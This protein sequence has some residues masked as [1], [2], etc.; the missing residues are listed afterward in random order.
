MNSK[1]LTTIVLGLIISG[2]AGFLLGQQFSN[3]ANI[4]TD[5]E[6]AYWRAPMDP[7]EVYDSA[8]KSRMGM[9]LVPVYADEQATGGDTNDEDKEVLYWRAPMDPT[10][11]Y[12]SPGKS[13]MGMDLVPV[14]EGEGNE[15]SGGMVNIDP[16]VVQNMGIKTTMVERQDLSR[17]IRTVGE[18]QYD[19]EKLFLVNTKISGW[20]E[21]LHVNFVGQEVAKGE[22]LMEIYSPELVSTQE[23][24]ILAKR[25]YDLL[26]QAGS[27][28]IAS[29]AERL[30]KAAR[31]RLSYW[32]ISEEEI[33]RIE[34]TQ[35]VKKTILIAAPSTG[36]VVERNAIEGAFI[37][38][39]KDLFRIAD[40]STVW[41]HASFYDN[42][43]PW[44]AEGQNVSMEL[45][46]LPGK[47]YEG[48]VSYIFPYL[49]EKARDVHVRLIFNNTI[50]IDLKPGMYAN[51]TLSGKTI[52]DALT[53]PSEALIRSGQRTLVFIAH[54]GGRFEPREVREGETGGESTN[55]VRIISGVME[56]ES[57]VTSAQFLIDSESRLQEAIQKML[58]SKA[59]ENIGGEEMTVGLNG[60]QDDESDMEEMDHSRHDETDKMEKPS[61]EAESM[62]EMDHSKHVMPDSTVIN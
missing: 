10:E 21:K 8:G 41:V 19:E 34:S 48:V 14:Y 52:P 32:D 15:S 49:R 29:D 12:D 27:E 33:A 56:G 24:L 18:V 9:D 59:S 35:E 26:K 5:R 6:I 38:A 23:E 30:L 46:Y 39:G 40:L 36:V 11:I 7:S 22:P 45:S 20:I 55:S 58:S 42:E 53:V 43:V 54:E 16:A 61:M 13:R 17:M 31:T 62:E 3:Q 37:N 50:N 60:M 1:K 44:I 4:D 47:S 28:E 2:A 51:V 57:V 25:N